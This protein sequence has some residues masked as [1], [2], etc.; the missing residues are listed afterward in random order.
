ML[1]DFE[2]VD[3]PDAELVG[4]RGERP[5]LPRRQK[6]LGQQELGVC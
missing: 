3:R 6:S 1:T 2:G 4:P 5:F